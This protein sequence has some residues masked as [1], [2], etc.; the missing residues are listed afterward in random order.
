VIERE[1]QFE[2]P[3]DLKRTLKPISSGKYDP[4]GRATETAMLRAT[5]TPEG[6]A[7]L[8]IEP[9]RAGVLVA[10][11]WGPGAEWILA[12]AD[13][14]IG[15]SDRLPN[16]F[17]EAHPELRPFAKRARGMRLA[18]PRRVVEHL[19]VLVLQQLVTGKESKRSFGRLVRH[20]SE[21]APGP[22]PDLWLPP[23]AEALRQLSPAKFVPLGI[24]ERMGETLRRVGEHASR[25]EEAAAMPAV[26]ALQRI[27]AVRGLGAWTANSLAIGSLGDPDAV[28][29]GDYHLPN[30]V[31]FHL[32]SEERGDD[33]RM[34]ELLEPYAGQRG[35]VVR[36]LGGGGKAPRRGPRIPVR[37]LPD[38][39]NR[40]L[41]TGRG[42]SA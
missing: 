1:L 5:R 8:G 11:A 12:R 20:T 41:R 29:T 19:T 21:P 30:T 28:V 32:A 22:F 2:A 3:L 23:S 31:A 33:A 34:L 39:A 26:E 4:T 38:D 17:L 37:D 7:T 14:W 13:D 27:Q 40:W 35:R 42:R 15:T 24:V 16:G 9:L 6:P 10:R 36:W 25:L 18:R